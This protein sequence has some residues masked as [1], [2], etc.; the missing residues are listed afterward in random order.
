MNY[1]KNEITVADRCSKNA[2]EAFTLGV[3]AAEEGIPFREN[4]FRY[5]SVEAR[6]WNRGHTMVTNAGQEARNG[7]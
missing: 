6:M 2:R 7:R 4:P 3:K 5:G 1:D